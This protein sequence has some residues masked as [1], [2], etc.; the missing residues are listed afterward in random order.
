MKRFN[1]LSQVVLLVVCSTLLAFGQSRATKD[2]N[3]SADLPAYQVQAAN[4]RTPAK[5]KI[6]P[7]QLNTLVS[8]EATQ[9]LMAFLANELG[10][11][12]SGAWSGTAGDSGWNLTFA[13]S[14]SGQAAAITESGVL[15][16]NVASWTDSGTVGNTP[17]TGSGKASLTNNNEIKWAQRANEGTVPWKTVVIQLNVCAAAP[18]CDV[19]VMIS[20]LPDQAPGA[21]PANVVTQLNLKTG[22]V[23]GSSVQQKAPGLTMLQDGSIAFKT[24]QISYDADTFTPQGSEGLPVGR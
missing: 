6:T 11:P 20:E 17:V 3:N 12:L 7:Q 18:E 22:T 10:A 21:G 4:N 1:G 14:I 16:G 9:N 8:Q 24:G 13:G 2:S 15:K 23:F 19:I 5:I